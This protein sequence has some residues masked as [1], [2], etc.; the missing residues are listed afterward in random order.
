MKSPEL[1]DLQVAFHNHLLNLPSAIAHE[2]ADGGRISVDHRLH[3]YHNAYRAR[4]LENLQNAYDKTWA[5]IGD[6]NFE[7]AALGYIEATPP[8]NQIGSVV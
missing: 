4:L 5:Y 8:T 6:E 3:I 7:N 2:V 1:T